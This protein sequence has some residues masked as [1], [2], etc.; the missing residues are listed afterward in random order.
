MEAKWAVSEYLKQ[1]NPLFE[2]DLTAASEKYAELNQVLQK[3]H[4]IF[5]MG[6]GEMLDEK[7]I[8]VA[9]LLM[10]AKKLEVEALK[11][12]KKAL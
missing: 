2:H 7:C 9:G 4:E 3:C 1:V 12:V 5:P 6:P 11:G 10:N 8:K